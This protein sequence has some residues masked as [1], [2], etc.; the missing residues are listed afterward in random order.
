MGCMT[1][2]YTNGTA[3][4]ARALSFRSHPAAAG[5]A[6]HPS[7]LHVVCIDQKTGTGTRR[8]GERWP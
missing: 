5:L 6:V 8:L 7:W 3:G 4:F 2:A 1:S